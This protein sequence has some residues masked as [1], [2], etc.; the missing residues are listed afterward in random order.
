MIAKYFWMLMTI[1]VVVWYLTITVHV[2]I[3]GSTDIKTMLR[4]LKDNHLT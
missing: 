4:G 2:A 3:R 1:A